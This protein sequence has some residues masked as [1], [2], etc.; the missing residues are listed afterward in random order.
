[1]SRCWFLFLFFRSN[2]FGSF[3][4]LIIFWF[5]FFLSSV[6]FIFSWFWSI[7]GFSFLSFLRDDLTLSWSSFIFFFVFSSLILIKRLIIIFVFLFL[8][9]LWFLFIAIL[10]LILESLSGLF[11]FSFSFLSFSLLVEYF[12]SLL[13]CITDNVRRWSSKKLYFC[14]SV[15]LRPPFC[16][17]LFLLKCL[18]DWIHS[19]SWLLS[20]SLWFLAMI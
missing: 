4:F 13:N 9:I 16:W 20:A 17:W 12:G 2:L 6:I 8:L 11:S 19:P 15:G 3:V 5:Y 7:F 14:L 18:L 10:I 1:M